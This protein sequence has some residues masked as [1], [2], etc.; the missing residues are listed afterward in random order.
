[1]GSGEYYYMF[2][3]PSNLRRS[4][5]F[6]RSDHGPGDA[7]LPEVARRSW[8]DYII[9]RFLADSLFI[10]LVALNTDEFSPEMFVFGS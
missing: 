4:L 6:P 7:R 10:R 8:V 5:R 1:M 9:L 2:D 3:L